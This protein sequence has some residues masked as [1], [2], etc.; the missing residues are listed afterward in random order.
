MPYIWQIQIKCPEKYHFKAVK[1]TNIKK[2]GRKSNMK[3][4]KIKYGLY[5]WWD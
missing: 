3:G 2:R 5:Y 1:I 4:S